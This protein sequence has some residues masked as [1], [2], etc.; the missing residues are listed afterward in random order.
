[1][2]IQHFYAKVLMLFKYFTSKFNVT[3]A[4]LIRM[5]KSF[6]KIGH[7]CKDFIMYRFL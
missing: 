7:T 6:K 4:S 1:M 2:T 5:I 3:N